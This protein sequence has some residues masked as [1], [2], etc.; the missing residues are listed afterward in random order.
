[1]DREMRD[2]EMRDRE[3]RAGIGGCEDEG[4]GEK[5]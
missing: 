3:R 1:M 4:L 5:G 2:R